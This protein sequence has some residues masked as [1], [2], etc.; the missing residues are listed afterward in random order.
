MSKPRYQILQIPEGYGLTIELT[1]DY[2]ATSP[3]KDKEMNDG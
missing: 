1:G 3:P 2:G